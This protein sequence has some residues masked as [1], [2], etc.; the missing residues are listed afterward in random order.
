VIDALKNWSFSGDAD[1]FA[2]LLHHLFEERDPYFVLA[3]FDAYCAAQ[4]GA[5]RD[6]TDAEAWSLRSGRNIARM[7]WFSADRA[8]REYATGIWGL[9]G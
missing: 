1:V 9:T 4:E 2:P 7:G 5:A 6:Y 3:D 8:V